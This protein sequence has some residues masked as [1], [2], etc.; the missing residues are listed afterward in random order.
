MNNHLIE[1]FKQRIIGSKNLTA[2]VGPSGAPYLMTDHF[3]VQF[4]PVDSEL[5]INHNTIA[6]IPSQDV[7]AALRTRYHTVD[8]ARQEV[9]KAIEMLSRGRGV[10]GAV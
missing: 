9:I 2:M 4:G 6:T 10:S 5:I 8:D 1:Y 7:V 3:V